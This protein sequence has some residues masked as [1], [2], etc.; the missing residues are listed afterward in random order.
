MAE[1]TSEFYDQLQTE[2][3]IRTFLLNV[4]NA[5]EPERIIH[6]I[7][8][9]DFELDSDRG[10]Q[11]DTALVSWVNEYANGDWRRHVY[12][13]DENEFGVPFVKDVINQ[14][15]KM[16]GFTRSD[17]VAYTNAD[18]CC[19]PGITGKI[20]HH[21]RKNGAAFT[22]RYDFVAIAQ[23][24]IS[25]SML[26]NGKFYPGSDAFFF[27]VDWW[28]EHEAEFPNM[29]V[30]REKVDEVLRQLIKLHGGQEIPKCIYHQVHANNWFQRPNDSG[31]IHNLKLAKEWRERTGLPENDWVWWN[32][33]TH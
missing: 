14:A 23:P 32:E 31:N 2:E 11:I 3:Q 4:P 16:R 19:T 7:T 18:V 5:K 12:G 9:P 27:T 20:L 8:L 29:L 21:C 6:T 10:R 13:A 33:I 15:I 30:G 17:I 22:H 24:F 25:D 26:R 1:Y 28:R